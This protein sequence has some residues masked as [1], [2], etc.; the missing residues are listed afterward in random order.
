M[1]K[2]Y[3]KPEIKFESF[4]LSTSI[5]ASCKVEA[6]S[7]LKE[8]YR[9]ELEAGFHSDSTCNIYIECYHVP[10]ESTGLFAS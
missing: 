7:E 9:Q 6:D 10:D 8:A 5:A 1:K 3:V 2:I 4:E